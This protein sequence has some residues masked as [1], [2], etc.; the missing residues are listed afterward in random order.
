MI[1]SL[2][3]LA[4]AAWTLS[5]TF[6]LFKAIDLTIGLRVSEDEETSG[7]DIEEHGIE[8]YADFAPR[9]LYIK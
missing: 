9:V 1:Q 2:G 4:V 3:V 8:S 7:L 5:T 6:I